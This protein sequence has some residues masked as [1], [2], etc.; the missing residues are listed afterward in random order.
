MDWSLTTEAQSGAAE[1]SD[2]QERLFFANAR[3]QSEPVEIGDCVKN[4]PAEPRTPR[5]RRAAGK[6]TILAAVAGAGVLLAGYS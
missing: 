1:Q 4:G 5:Q 6:A 2:S 3:H